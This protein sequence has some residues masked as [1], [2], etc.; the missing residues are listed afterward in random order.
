MVIIGA[1]ILVPS[2][3]FQDPATRCKIGY[4]I[5]RIHII[6]QRD[7]GNLSLSHLGRAKVDT[8]SQTTF[9]NAI[10]SMKMFEFWLNF[11][12]R[13]FLR[14]PINNIPALVQKMAWRRPGD[15]PLSEPMM[16]SLPTHIYAYLGLNELSQII[17]MYFILQR[18]PWFRRESAKLTLGIWQS[19]FADVLSSEDVTLTSWRATVLT[20]IFNMFSSWIFRISWFSTIFDDLMTSN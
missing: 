15:K 16:A 12:W 7:F 1:T 4:P 20:T 18:S 6:D 11:H 17:R 9:W 14:N 5:T 8:I 10:Y 3:H 13:L 19:K 2:N